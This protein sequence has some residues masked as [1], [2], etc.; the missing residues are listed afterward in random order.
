MMENKSQK[1]AKSV[2]P[3][4]Q[5]KETNAVMLCK[6]NMILSTWYHINNGHIP[7]ARVTEEANSINTA[8]DH[9]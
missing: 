1:Q 6:P 9:H 7:K 5:K 3:N 4:H 2:Q 8:P